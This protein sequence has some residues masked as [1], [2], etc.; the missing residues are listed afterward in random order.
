MNTRNQVDIGELTSYIGD[1]WERS[2]LPTLCDFVRIPNKS[3]LFDAEW[4][5]HGHME[6]AAALLAEWCRRQPLKGMSVEIASLPGRTPLLFIEIAGNSNDTVLMYGHFDKQ[7]EFTGWHEGLSP[8]EPVIREGR[9]YGRGAADDG[10]AVFSSLTA[11]AA[12]QAQGIAHARCVVLIE[13]CEESGSFDL[14]FHVE[15][16]ATRIGQPSLVV[17]LDAECAD[18]ER[19]WMTTS[20]RGN[21]V[22]TLSVQMLTEGVHSGSGSGI[23]ASCVDVL[24]QLLDRVSNARTG[25]LLK[26]LYVEIPEERLAQAAATATVLDDSVRAGMPFA[27]GVEPVSSAAVDLILNSTWRPTL[28]IT[29]IDGLP[30]VRDAGNVLVPSIRVKLSFRLPPSGDPNEAQEAVRRA[31]TND[32]PFNA[33]VE[34]VLDSGNAGWNAPATASWLERAAREA[35][36][37]YFDRDA[38]S[39]GTGGTIPFMAMLGTRFPSTQFMVTGVLGP[40]SNAH[41]PN[42]FLHIDYAKRLT[43]AVAHVLAAHAGRA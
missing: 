15:A 17:C 4:E 37:N 23:A 35:S 30:A 11:I 18:Y 6:K 10:Y 9:L 25:M 40:Q 7:P 12:L 2:I 32:P 34:W 22:G 38:M 28:V 27:P 21:L 31:L 29:G 13:G 5:A 36:R 41:G 1:A 39:M 19:L 43:G 42:E 16:L 8:W 24:R 26:E 14:P 3:P 20:L 33:R